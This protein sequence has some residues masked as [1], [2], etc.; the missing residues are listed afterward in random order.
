MSVFVVM[1]H[2]KVM[3]QTNPHISHYLVNGILRIA[4]PI[5]LIINGY[6]ICY[7]FDNGGFRKVINNLL[8]LYVI[9]MVIYSYFWIKGFSSINITLSIIFGYHILW[10]FP[11]II[12]SLIIL[13]KVKDF[14][15]RKI[16]LISISLYLTGYFIQLL[17]SRGIIFGET[18]NGLIKIITYRNFLFDC[19]P[20][21]YIGY[22][23]NRKNLYISKGLLTLISA[24]LF[25]LLLLESNFNTYIY[26]ESFQTDIM[27]VPPFLAAAIFLLSTKVTIRSDINSKL[28]SQFATSIFLVHVLCITISSKI[29]MLIKIDSTPIYYSLVLLL[30]F[31]LSIVLVYLKQAKKNLILLP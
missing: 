7:S 17:I 15:V 16:S 30:S 22:L 5:F 3:N 27:I 28:I 21:I 9:W 2:L 8:K 24:I 12:L 23:L 10:Y 20:I 18:S 14:D 19:F 25:V 4:V 11:G 13:Y 1:L 6:F 31:I 26:G 29:L